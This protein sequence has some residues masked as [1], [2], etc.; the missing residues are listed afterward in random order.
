MPRRNRNAHAFTISAD[1]LAAQAEQLTTEIGTKNGVPVYLAD[2]IQ[3]YPVGIPRLGKS[4]IL[5]R[6]LIDWIKEHSGCQIGVFDGKQIPAG[7]VTGNGR[8]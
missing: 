4:G 6:W 2:E 8:D 1:K 7:V 3:L 5:P